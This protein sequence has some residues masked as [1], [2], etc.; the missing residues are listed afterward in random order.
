MSKSAGTISGRNAAHSTVHDGLADS[1][2]MLPYAFEYRNVS[3]VPHS[4]TALDTESVQ[5]TRDLSQRS[6]LVK[7]TTRLFFF[8]K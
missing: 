7:E 8:A 3:A 6:K 4:R 2:L 1:V 5:C